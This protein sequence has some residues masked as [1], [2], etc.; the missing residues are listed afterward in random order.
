VICRA[1]LKFECGMQAAE[2]GSATGLGSSNNVD[3]VERQ[4]V[5]C[6]CVCVR[7]RVRVRVRVHVRVRVRVRAC[8]G[9]RACIRTSLTHTHA[10]I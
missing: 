5:V 3:M 4:G 2:L 9:M 8:V 7:V 6:V 10:L 1:A